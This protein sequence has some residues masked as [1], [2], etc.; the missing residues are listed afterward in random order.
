MTLLRRTGLG[1]TPQSHEKLGKEEDDDQ[2]VED[3][4]VGPVGA[5]LLDL[6]MCSG[7]VVG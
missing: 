1:F 4:D 3:L 7:P 6:D 2:G 5:L